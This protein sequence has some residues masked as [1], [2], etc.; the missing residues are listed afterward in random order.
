MTFP[1]CGAVYSV[2]TEVAVKRNPRPAKDGQ[3][4]CKS[5]ESIECELA[6]RETAHANGPVR[7]PASRWDRRKREDE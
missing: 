7:V 5:T 3:D 1:S 6:S 4:H 2:R